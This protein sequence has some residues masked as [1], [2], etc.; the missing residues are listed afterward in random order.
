[1][2]QILNHFS[3]NVRQLGHLFNVSFELPER[4]MMDHKQVYQQLNHHEAAFHILQSLACNELLHYRELT[5]NTAKT[6]L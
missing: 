5:A 1:M 4:A 2:M 3:N 6:T